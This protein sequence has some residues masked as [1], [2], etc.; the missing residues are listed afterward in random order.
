MKEIYSL[1]E[2]LHYD[3][4]DLTPRHFLH[5][6]AME[7]FLWKRLPEVQNPT[8]IDLHPSLGN[9]DHLRSMILK[10][11]ETHFP[12]GTGWEGLIHLKSTQDKNAL[13]S[14]AYI[15]VVLEIPYSQMLKLS[16]DSDDLEDEADI[17]VEDDTPFHI[18]VCM[19]AEASFCLL[20]AQYLQCD[21]GFKRVI[22]FKEFELGG[23]HPETRTGITYCHIYL[24]RQS[25]VAHQIIFQKIEEIVLKDT[26]ECLQWRHLHANDI[27]DMVGILEIAVDQHGRQAKGLGRHLKSLARKLPVKADLH[28]PHCS[29][30]ELSEYDHL[31]CI[32]RLCMNHFFHNIRK[33][34]VPDTVR[35]AMHSLV[36]MEHKNWDGAL[37]LIS[38]EGRKASRDWLNDK[39]R[40]KFAFPG[41]CWEKSF[42]PRSVWL[43]GN[44]TTNLIESMHFDVNL[45]GT[46]CT[47]NTISLGICASYQCGHMSESITRGIKHK[48][49]SHQKMFATQAVAIEHSNKRLKEAHQVKVDK[50]S[51]LSQA[52]IGKGSPEHAALALQ[53][54]TKHYNKALEASLQTVGSGS[55]RVG[56]LLPQN[57]GDARQHRQP[58]SM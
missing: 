36:C 17:F 54:A 37:A 5:H 28:E 8:L 24:N 10:V 26:G 7:A 53:R 39:I 48:S 23:L 42:I 27:S 11:Q 49:N 51:R 52:R 19:T 55:G 18:V 34:S 35:Q 22:G 38:S 44:S 14:N 12:F 29:I 47:L 50:E 58:S 46:S 1:L 40:A 3:L 13:E 31:R 2:S 4:P 30:Q 6:A 9:K 20:K 25:A 32:L 56:L 43:S 57:V 16:T 15:H 33:T 21:I 45:E 41:I